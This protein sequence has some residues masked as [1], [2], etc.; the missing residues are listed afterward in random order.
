MTFPTTQKIAARA[1]ADG[2]ASFNAREGLVTFPTN[3]FYSG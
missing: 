2:T 3:R 1:Q